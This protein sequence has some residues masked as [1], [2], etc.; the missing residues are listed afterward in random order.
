MERLRRR[1]DLLAAIADE[2]QELKAELQPRAPDSIA[3]D[4]PR[5][6][7]SRTVAAS[8]PTIDVTDLGRNIPPISVPPPRMETTIDVSYSLLGRAGIGAIVGF[9]AGVLLTQT[10]RD[11]PW[12]FGLITAAAAAFVAAIAGRR[13]RVV[14]VALVCAVLVWVGSLMLLS[15]TGGVLRDTAALAALFLFGAPGAA[16]SAAVVWWKDRRRR[17]KEMATGNAQP[18]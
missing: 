9:I 15:A 8:V 13:P 5:V 16:L 2:M 11:L 10:V 18:V 12:Q 1:R 14:V 17:R 3:P 6:E 7:E 4:P